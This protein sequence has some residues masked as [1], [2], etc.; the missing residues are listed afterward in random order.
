MAKQP[1]NHPKNWP[2][3]PLAGQD[4]GPLDCVGVAGRH[5]NSIINCSLGPSGNVIKNPIN[6]KS[7]CRRT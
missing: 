6:S 3:N 4:F 5:R 2:A 7:N 1:E